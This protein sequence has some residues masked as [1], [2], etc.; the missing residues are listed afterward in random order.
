[1]LKTWEC[2]GFNDFTEIQRTG[3]SSFC[4]ISAYLASDF[5]LG[6]GDTVF[7]KTDD[8]TILQEITSFIVEEEGGKYR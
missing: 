7:T 5:V 3:I 6:I 1:M 4:K 8:V 2:S